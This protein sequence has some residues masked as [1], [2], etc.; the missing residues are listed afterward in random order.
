M[1]YLEKQCEPEFSTLFWDFLFFSRNM[2]YWKKKKPER[3]KPKSK[4]TRSKDVNIFK[5]FDTYCQIKS[6]KAVLNLYFLQYMSLD[7][8][9]PLQHWVLLFLVFA[10][11][12]GKKSYYFS[13]VYNNSETSAH[14]YWAFYYFLLI[15]HV[16]LP[17]F[18]MG[19]CF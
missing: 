14:I 15:V 2:F 4:V 5:A 1:L 6:R 17:I 16:L 10:D 13:Y 19:I 7:F 12:T 9:I 18:P 8:P 3:M 11:L